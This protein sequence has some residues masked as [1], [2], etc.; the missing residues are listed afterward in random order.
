MIPNSIREKA[1]ALASEI[2]STE[3]YRDLKEKEMVLKNDSDAQILL[4]DFQQK[5]Q[6]F[7]SKKVTGEVDPEI[8][9]ELTSIQE[10]LE[11]R[12]SV[13]KFIDS[14]GRFLNML[15]EVGNIISKEINFDFGEVYR[16]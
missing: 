1:L 12:D 11:K 2:K 9:N 8:I 16:R 10:E 7:I 13:V 5:Q 4:A 3:E 6:E 14:Y 15:G